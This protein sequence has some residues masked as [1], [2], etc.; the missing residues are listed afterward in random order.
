MEWKPWK[1]R[2]EFGKI[3]KNSRKTLDIERDLIYRRFQ[4]AEKFFLTVD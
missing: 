1:T 4:S 2:G 3:E